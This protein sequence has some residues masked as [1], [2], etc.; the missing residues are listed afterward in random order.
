MDLT[1]LLQTAMSDETLN[2]ISD[3]LGI[4]NQQ[5]KVA[6]S[7]AIPILVAAL[8]KNAKQG[9]V[10]NIDRA[11]EKHDGSVL[12][13][14]QGFLSAGN[15]SDGVGILE[16]IL[17]GNQSKV[18]NAVSKSSGLDTGQTI[19][20][21]AMLAPIIMGFLGKQ[22]NRGVLSSGGGLSSILEG[23][24]GGIPKANQGS[25]GEIDM[26]II[27]VLL[28]NNEKNEDGGLMDIGGKILG[29]LFGKK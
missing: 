9:D 24:V 10:D 29:G 27:D 3:H 21:L 28:N 4:D 13:N 23:L 2:G 6:I 26:N 22:K 8:N 11:L 25:K 18:E 16:H 5:A 19:K 7:S 12:D 14:V 1:A 17:G 20:L 15:F